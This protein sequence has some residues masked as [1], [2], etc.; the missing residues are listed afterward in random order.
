MFELIGPTVFSGRSQ[1]CSN[2]EFMNLYTVILKTALKIE[3]L[4]A[5]G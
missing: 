5:S 2:H 3:K 1:S 4:L